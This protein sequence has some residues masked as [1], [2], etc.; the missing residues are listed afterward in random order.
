MAVIT[1]PLVWPWAPVDCWP[2]GGRVP[3]FGEVLGRSAASLPRSSDSS[4]G[5]RGVSRFFAGGGVTAGRGGG[6]RVS[7]RGAGAFSGGRG[8]GTG[9]GVGGGGS[10]ASGGG[11]ASTSEAGSG[12]GASAGP[13]RTMVSERIDTGM[14]WVI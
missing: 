11:A 12:D 3:R 7:G 2:A 13:A 1:G 5:G 10:T 9:V 4:R 6:G 8:V 14:V